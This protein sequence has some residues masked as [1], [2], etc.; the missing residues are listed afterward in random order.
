MMS[1]T[2]KREQKKRDQEQLEFWLKVLQVSQKG[3]SCFFFEGAA[4]VFQHS[5]LIGMGCQRSSALSNLKS[6]CTLAFHILSDL[7]KHVVQEE[8]AKTFTPT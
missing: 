6:L 4:L 5:H 1:D 8:T 3:K 7:T 2:M